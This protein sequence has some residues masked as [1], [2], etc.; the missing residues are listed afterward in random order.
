MTKETIRADLTA[1]ATDYIL[2]RY[3]DR[4]MEEPTENRYQQLLQEFEIKKR[5]FL[6]NAEARLV[7]INLR[8]VWNDIT[9][10]LCPPDNIRVHM[11][12]SATGWKQQVLD[13][14]EQEGMKVN[15]LV[16]CRDL[17]EVKKLYPYPEPNDVC[18][19]TEVGNHG[20]IYVAYV[21]QGRWEQTLLANLI[22]NIDD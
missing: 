6:N 10:G 3:S 19:L 15:M 14:A 18:Y 16:S 13:K 17:T 20:D 21:E 5:Q 7:K 1:E 8:W 9:P 11:D 12:E 2:D 4:P 22:G